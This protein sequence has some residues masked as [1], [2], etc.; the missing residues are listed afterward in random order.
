M[1]RELS[2]VAVGLVLIICNPPQKGPGSPILSH[3]I[4]DK[5][6][7]VTDIFRFYG[8]PTLFVRSLGEIC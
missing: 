6:V 1:L 8:F 7:R 4:R 5:N 3:F 2:R